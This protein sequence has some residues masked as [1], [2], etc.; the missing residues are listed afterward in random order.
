MSNSSDVIKDE[1]DTQSLDYWIKY[2]TFG[3]VD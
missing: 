2:E 3:I 1:E